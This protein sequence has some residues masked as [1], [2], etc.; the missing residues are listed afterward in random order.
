VVSNTTLNVTG[1][2]TGGTITCGD[3]SAASA[4]LA[5]PYVPPMINTLVEQNAALALEITA[6]EEAMN[7][8]T[9][10]LQEVNDAIQGPLE[11]SSPMSEDAMSMYL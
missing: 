7:A 9:A 6:L 1:A 5:A 8:V 2:I 11:E 4:T 10:G 3:L